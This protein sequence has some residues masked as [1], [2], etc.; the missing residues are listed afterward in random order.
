MTFKPTT[1][2]PDYTKW[3]HAQLVAAATNYHEQ[4]IAMNATI[5]ALRLA[6]KAKE[7]TE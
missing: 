2:L 4:L 6:L 5:E 3:N 7:S 1:D